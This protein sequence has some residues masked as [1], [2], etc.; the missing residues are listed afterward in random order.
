MLRP[1]TIGPVA[2]MAWSLCSEGDA[3]RPG[4]PGAAGPRREESH[5]KL[6]APLLH[7]QLPGS[8]RPLGLFTPRAISTLQKTFEIIAFLRGDGET[9]AGKSHS[10]IR[11]EHTVEDMA[12]PSAPDALPQLQ[13][14]PSEQTGIGQ[15]HG[16]LCFPPPELPRSSHIPLGNTEELPLSQQMGILNP[17]TMHRDEEEPHS[18]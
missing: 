9:R 7:S 12:I 18:V 17:A 16:N 8:S 2:S 15:S 4:V 5:M 6:S 10:K 13:G 11:A 14:L 3:G 1:T